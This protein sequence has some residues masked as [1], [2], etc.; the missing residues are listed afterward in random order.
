MLLVGELGMVT[1]K[2]YF[3]AVIGGLFLPTVLL[4]NS[5]LSAGGDFH[6][7]FFIVS[8]L[9]IFILLFIG[10]LHERYLFFAASVAPRMPGIPAS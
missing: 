4:A 8:T 9:L 2:R 6:P 1:L 3:F 5:E 10:E 7:L